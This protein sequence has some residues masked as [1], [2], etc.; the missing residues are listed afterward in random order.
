MTRRDPHPPNPNSP[1]DP[2]AG[3]TPDPAPGPPPVPGSDTLPMVDTARTGGLVFARDLSAAH[4][5]ELGWDS[6]H[7]PG[8]E[9]LATPWIHLDHSMPEAKRYVEQAAGIPPGAVAALLAQDPR[10]RFARF[11]G[12]AVLILRG[13]NHNED[14]DPEEMVVLR[15]WIEPARVVSLRMSRLATVREL[16]ERLAAGD[17]PTSTG[18]LVADIIDGLTTRVERFLQTLD[19]EVYELEEGVLL[20][21]LCPI[22]ERVASVRRDAIAVR[23]YL[24]PQREAV[25]AMLEHHAPSRSGAGLLDAEAKDRV[26][27]FADRLSR[28]IEDFDEARDRAAVV[29]EQHRSAVDHRMNRTGYVLTLVATVTLPPTLVT[30]FLGMNVIM[31]WGEHPWAFWIVLVLLAAMIAGQVWFFKKRGWL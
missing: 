5:G 19:D 11:A 24:V 10:P 8:N 14:A 7:N 23:R 3:P 17:G 20:D 27:E 2:P 30:G 4:R 6:V 18:A 12:G 9:P 21:P 13:I 22:A 15:M 26:G 16:R 31:P 25:N 28:A 1:A 29:G